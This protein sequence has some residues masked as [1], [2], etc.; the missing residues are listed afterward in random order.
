MKGTK[1]PGNKLLDTVS[2]WRGASFTPGARV[3][4]YVTRTVASFTL[5]MKKLSRDSESD[6]S[7]DG[8][9]LSAN[10]TRAI[11]A[12]IYLSMHHRKFIRKSSANIRFYATWPS[13]CCGHILTSGL[14]AAL[15]YL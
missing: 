14:D 5:G 9:E 2:M 11:A 6:N 8:T 15:S 7:S 3:S 4:G 1:L 13:I 10:M 12:L